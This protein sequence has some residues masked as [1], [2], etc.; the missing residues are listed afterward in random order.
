M[1]SCERC[2]LEAA[3]RAVGSGRPTTDVYYEV[4][5]ER[6]EAGLVCTPKEQAGQ[7]WDEEKQRDS[8]SSE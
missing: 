5:K 6:E 3:A 8:R 2:W 7:W 1:A 4:M